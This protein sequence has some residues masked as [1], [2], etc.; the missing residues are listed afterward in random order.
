MNSFEK[1]L[2]ER[3]TEFRTI[4]VERSRYSLCITAFEINGGYKIFTSRNI[5]H[6]FSEPTRIEDC[7]ELM[8][9]NRN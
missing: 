8:E 1:I 2:L 4:W 3:Y 7:I 9:R 5:Y 6:G